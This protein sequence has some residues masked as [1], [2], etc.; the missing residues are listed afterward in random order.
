MVEKVG[1][2]GAI[3]NPA[4]WHCVNRKNKRAASVESILGIQVQMVGYHLVAV[5]RQDIRT[6]FDFPPAEH[7]P[8]EAPTGRDCVKI[9]DY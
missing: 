9:P 3:D 1:I 4:D 6:G 5:F 7:I 2:H 8:D